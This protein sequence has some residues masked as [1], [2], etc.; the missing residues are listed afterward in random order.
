MH[1]PQVSN[2]AKKDHLVLQMMNA[3]Q[4]Q[5]SPT[6][7]PKALEKPKAP[8]VLENKEG[9]EDKEVDENAE[10]V[11]VVNTNQPNW[12]EREGVNTSYDMEAAAKKR[13]EQRRGI[14]KRRRHRRGVAAKRKTRRRQGGA[15]S[16]LK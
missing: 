9:K 3:K 16:V 13:S 14:T 10:S 7:I 5:L 1:P 8:V 12:M 6:K 15:V 2:S 4:L 11:H